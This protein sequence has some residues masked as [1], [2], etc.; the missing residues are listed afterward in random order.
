MKIEGIASYVDKAGKRHSI[1]GIGSLPDGDELENLNVEGSF[2]FDKIS[3]DDIKISGECNGKSINGKKISTEGTID[4]EY[5]EVETFKLSGSADINKIVAKKIT[6]ESR[7]GSIG[8]IKCD[9]LKI[10]HGDIH[11]VGASIISKIFGGKVSHNNNSRVR[12]KN[13]E[14]ETIHLENCAVDVITCKDASIGKNCV[15]DKLLVSGDCK[16][17]DDSTVGETVHT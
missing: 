5:V 6:M 15:I 14:A 4:V 7:G 9:E 16:V 10:F 11:E 13:I 2:S 3:C 8:D 1:E 17:A 12:I